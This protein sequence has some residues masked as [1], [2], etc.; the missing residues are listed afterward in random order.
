[1]W[2]TALTID[3]YDEEH[4]ALA[5]LPDGRVG[6]VKSMGAFYSTII[7]EEDIGHEFD[8]V[9]PNEDYEILGYIKVEREEE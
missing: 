2:W 5:Q 1:M 9:V 6:I 4:I 8:L 7:V 3:E